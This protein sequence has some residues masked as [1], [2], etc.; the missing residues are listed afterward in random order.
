M[1]VGEAFI[2]IVTSYIFFFLI[3]DLSKNLSKSFE[4]KQN[5]V[6]DLE[7]FASHVMRCSDLTDFVRGVVD[8]HL[9]NKRSIK[10]YQEF[11]FRLVCDDGKVYTLFIHEIKRVIS[12]QKEIFE[13]SEKS[14]SDINH[15]TLA[16]NSLNDLLQAF[17]ETRESG[18]PKLGGLRYSEGELRKNEPKFG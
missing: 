2:F 6:N 1:G 8:I 16:L 13:R 18:A 12:E 15:Y 4:E 17:V 7:S 3:N 10:S 9:K 5:E 14:N 11:F